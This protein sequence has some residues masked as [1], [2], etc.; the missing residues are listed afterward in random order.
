MLLF[1]V[2][3]FV[4]LCTE[5]VDICYDTGVPKIIEG[6]VDDK[7]TGTAGVEDGVI[8]VFNTRMM[9]VG[10]GEGMCVE[11]GTIDGFVFALCP[12]MNYSIVDTEVMNIL[13]GMWSVVWTNIDE[14]VVTSVTEAETH[15]LT[16][17]MV[18]ILH[19]FG[20][21]RDVGDF[22]WSGETVKK[23]GWGCVN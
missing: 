12:L 22:C 20:L 14:R 15:P 8:S 11:R 9:E 21:G 1:D 6:I 5:H 4:V 18:S 2:L 10:G 23:G 3:E 19:V 17:W 13:G 7:L 16:A